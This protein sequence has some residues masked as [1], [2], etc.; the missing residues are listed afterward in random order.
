MKILV[1]EDEKN[2][3]DIVIKYLKKSGFDCM[4][5]SNGF[6]ALE[7]FSKEKFHLILL[8]VMMPGI[9]G[10]EVLESIRAISDVP[11]IMLT[12]KQEEVDRLKG[13]EK[14]ADDYVVKP[15]SPREL[16]SRVRVFMKRVYHNAD[17][18]ILIVG[19]LRL[20]TSTM[21]FE[22]SG[23]VIDLTG[24][25]FKLLHTFM[26]HKGQIL[27]REQLIELAFGIGY[28]GFDRN[29]DSYIKRI[30]NK[31][32]D[33]PKSPK[34]LVTKYGVGYIFGGGIDDNT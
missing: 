33:D 17:E 13:F 7:L 22:K 26:R 34:Y 28:S 29:I 18:L 32:E 25:E 24:T 3:S 5:A 14:G 30:R 21:K 27:S 31:L 2:I 12:A 20:Y 4:L 10:F 1:V 9:N 16:I 23:V 8:D 15:F 11:I 6:E 19:D